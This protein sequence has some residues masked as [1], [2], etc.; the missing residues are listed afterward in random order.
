MLKGAPCAR[1]AP[2]PAAW[3][4]LARDAVVWAVPYARV[5]GWRVFRHRAARASLVPWFASGVPML[6]IAQV[7]TAFWGT[8]NC[9][10][11]QLDH[12]IQYNGLVPRSMS[13]YRWRQA[14]GE[15]NEHQWAR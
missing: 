5:G 4:A 8:S 11:L 9:I 1:I 2:N 7:S 15:I 14:P 6:L 3:R 13:A 10:Q 12:K